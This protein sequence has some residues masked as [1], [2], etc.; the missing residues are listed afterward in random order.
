M[1]FANCLIDS[2]RIKLIIVMATEDIMVKM[3]II[4]VAFG[5]D[6]FTV[7]Y[8]ILLTTVN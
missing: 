1:Y 2:T 3:L 8:I 4:T 6:F 7:A 5:D